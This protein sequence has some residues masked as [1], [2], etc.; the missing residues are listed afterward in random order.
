MH[1]PTKIDY[2]KLLG[3]DMVSEELVKGV[4][5][6]N[7]TVAAKLGAKVG[8]KTSTTKTDQPMLM[9]EVGSPAPQSCKAWADGR[10]FAEIAAGNL[11]PNLSVR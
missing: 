11:G 5:F 6:N 10:L 8:G 3:F 7:P 1:R 4:D 9:P 2:S